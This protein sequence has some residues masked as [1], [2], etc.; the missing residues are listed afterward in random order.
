MCVY[1]R[2]VYSMIQNILYKIFIKKILKCNIYK[3]NK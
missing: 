3:C 1:V 2:M